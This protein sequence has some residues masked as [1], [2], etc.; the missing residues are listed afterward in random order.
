[1]I[2]ERATSS[3]SEERQGAAPFAL[4]L[5]R[6][7]SGTGALGSI[8]DVQP[9]LKYLGEIF[10]PDNLEREENFFRFLRFRVGEDLDEA[11][12]QSGPELFD[13]YIA[14]QRA[15][16]PGC[17]PIIDVKY[18]SLHHLGGGWRGLVEAP[19][20][21]RHAAACG[22]PIIHLTRNNF[23]E[24]FV[25][26]RLAEAN[27]VW[28]ARSAEEARVTSTVVD[29]RALSHYIET[30]REEVA[31]VERWLQAIPKL[32]A[33]TID[34]GTLFD[35]S[36]ALDE[37]IANRLAS[38]LGVAAFRDR[39]PRFVKQAPRLEHAVE[40]LALLRTALSGTPHAWM[41]KPATAES[42]P[43]PRERTAAGTPEEKP[44][45]SSAV[46]HQGP[47]VATHGA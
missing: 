40:N 34:Y 20:M 26:G 10:H 24:S 27:R 16:Y 35:R 23:V 19:W 43:R 28:H 29:I 8:L 37:T 11:L 44:K 5:A 2:V 22:A 45:V 12:P 47:P 41:V 46:P 4:L 13:A 14:E 25:S 32:R 36:G 42:P 31:L 38:L 33:E 1:M 39:Q 17:L 7:R 21:L 18:R 9:A 3:S 6:Q 30:T 15:R